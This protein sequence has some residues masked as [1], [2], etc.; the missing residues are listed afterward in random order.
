MGEKAILYMFWVGKRIQGKQL[1]CWR[2]Y[3][4]RIDGFEHSRGVPGTIPVLQ[5]FPQP[6]CLG[7]RLQLDWTQQRCKAIRISSASKKKPV[8]EPW[9]FFIIIR[10]SVYGGNRVAACSNPTLSNPGS[11]IWCL[12]LAFYEWLYRHVLYKQIYSWARCLSGLFD[13]CG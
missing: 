12:A 4:W 9:A 6:N 10:S 3:H 5:G 11:L 7:S 1:P 2:P 8:Q 13:V